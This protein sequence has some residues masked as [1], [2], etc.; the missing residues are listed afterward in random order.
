MTF[1]NRKRFV[2]YLQILG[3]LITYTTVGILAFIGL[4]NV[5][6]P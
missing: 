3:Y 1:W 5:M 2:L 4:V 6:Y